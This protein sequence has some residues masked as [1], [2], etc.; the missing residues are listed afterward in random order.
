MT[1]IGGEVLAFIAAE[2]RSHR[3]ISQLFSVI[4]LL[5]SDFSPLTSEFLLHSLCPMLYA[6][7]PKQLQLDK[8]FT[9]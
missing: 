8:T 9:C 6:L 7:C 5:V 3:V 2:S 1:E 4:R